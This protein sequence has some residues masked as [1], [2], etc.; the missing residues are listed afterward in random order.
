MLLLAPLVPEPQTA[1]GF[2][3]RAYGTHVIWYP[4]V[5]CAVVAL[6]AWAGTLRLRVLVLASSAAFVLFMAGNVAD[7][8]PAADILKVVFGALVGAGFVRAVE[9]P[10]WLVP[11]AICVPLTDAWSVYSERGVTRAIIDR[12]AEEPAWINW[13][14][15][16]TP[17][18][19]LPYEQFGRLGIVDVL[20]LAL[21]LGVAQR[22]RF[23]VVLGVVTCSTGLLVTS[24]LVLEGSDV[25]I[26]AL[27][28]L[29]VAFLVAYASP[30]WRDARAAWQQR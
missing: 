3:L 19:G 20:F 16:A 5:A 13:P 22:W 24:I 15:I 9:R 14:T 26:P 18:A 29:C 11:I 25:A 2:R 17:I 23:G 7:V 8:L 28:L 6:T 4:L 21:F 10:W 27:P 12:A 1:D 30:L